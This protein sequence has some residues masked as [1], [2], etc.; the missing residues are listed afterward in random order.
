MASITYVARRSLATGHVLG[1]TYSIET[2]LMQADRGVRYLRERQQSLSGHVETNFFGSTA[3][4]TI[5][6][7]PL[8]YEDT[9]ILREMLDSTAD[10]QEFSF[11]PYGTPDVAVRLLTVVREDDGHDE[12]RIVEVGD[13]QVD[14][15]GFSFQLREV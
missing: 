13:W 6:T 10:G 2:D 5:R 14:R 12:E 7:L 15:F 8:P 4:W 9:E 1:V 3:I 11:D